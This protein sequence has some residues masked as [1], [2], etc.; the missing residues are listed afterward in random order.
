MKRIKLIM[1]LLFSLFFISCGG[2]QEESNGNSTTPAVYQNNTTTFSDITTTFINND[3]SDVSAPSVPLNF[4][5]LALS[6]TEV[7]LFWDA[8]SDNVAVSG[9]KIYRNGSY[10]NFTTSTSENDTGL[11]GE[12]QYCYSVLAVDSSG[13]ESAQT[14]QICATTPQTPWQSSVN[15][16]NAIVKDNSGNFYV[17][18]A[19]S[20]GGSASLE[21]FDNAGIKKWHIDINSM[22]QCVAGIASDGVN[23]YVYWFTDSSGE[24]SDKEFVSAY[25]ANGNLLWEIETLS[26]YGGAMSI[27]ADANGIYI[28][29]A[30]TVAN[31]PSL[32]KLDKNGNI[33]KS[34]TVKDASGSINVYKGH[35][36]IVGGSLSDGNIGAYVAEYDSDLNLIFEMSDHIIYQSA[37]DYNRLFS[38]IVDDS[39]FYIGGYLKAENGDICFIFAS[40][41]LSGNRNWVKIDNV[42][43][44]NLAQDGIA[45]AIDDDSIYTTI[46]SDFFGSTRILKLKK[47]D[48]S[49]LW[50][51]QN[52][53]TLQQGGFIWTELSVIYN[54]ILFVPDSQTNKIVLFDAS[55]GAQIQ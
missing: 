1:I 30:F 5:V 20:S 7:K 3:N 18:G 34:V 21:K 39:G 28:S 13:N 36:Y 37:N 6:Y 51:S 31:S 47:S 19:N 12:T 53:M 25:D 38:I 42:D 24:F 33:I 43:A 8:S 52:T 16:P 49:E 46:S 29:S 10:I 40:Y 26:S 48:G 9:Y 45:V 54:G 55:T 50:R 23:V 22:A 41:D 32:K 11:S 14:D 35:I 44:L 27:A 4:S 17:A 15:N 2:G